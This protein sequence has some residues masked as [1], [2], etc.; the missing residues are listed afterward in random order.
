MHHPQQGMTRSKLHMRTTLALA[1]AV[2]AC[3]SRPQASVPEACP[4]AATGLVEQLGVRMRRVSLLA[5][6][7][8]LVRELDDAYAGLVAPALLDEWTHNPSS[9]PGRDVSSPWPARITVR[10]RRG[11][12]KT[13]TVTGD[14]IY[15]ANPDTM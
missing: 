3:E 7:S 11:E 8:V 2:V 4:V 1:A 14:L 13:C 6:D 10:D 12:G 5:P 15:V 9:A